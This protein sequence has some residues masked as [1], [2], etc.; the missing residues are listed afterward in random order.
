MIIRQELILIYCHRKIMSALLLVLTCICCSTCALSTV[1]TAMKVTAL[2]LVLLWSLVEVHSQ[3]V[4]YL[5]FMGETLPNHAFVNLSLVGTDGIDSVQCHTDLSTCCSGTQGADRGD[6]YFPSG[7]RLGFSNSAGN[8]YEFRTA[9]RVDLRRRNN[10]DMPS[11]IYRCDIE[12][13]AVN[14]ADSDDNTDRETVYA[15]IYAT[16]GEL[17]LL[18]QLH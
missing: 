3:T 5:T 18:L 9:Q 16:G 4:P 6:W 12:T 13:N 8:I 17:T 15:G 7:D 10:A 1:G 2:L 14:S 11:G